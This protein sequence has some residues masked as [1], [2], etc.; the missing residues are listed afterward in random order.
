MATDPHKDRLR[1]EREEERKAL[2]RLKEMSE[3]EMSRMER[4]RGKNIFS[5]SKEGDSP[6]FGKAGTDEDSQRDQGASPFR[7]F[8]TSEQASASVPP[9]PPP[10]PPVDN[11]PQDDPRRFDVR[12]RDV[13][14]E[15][16][17]AMLT[18]IID[19]LENLPRD[20][21]DELTAG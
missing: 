14:Q 7:S 4:E 6:E 19:L 20:I 1:K 15:D 10:P 5:A 8:E 12:E 9:P 3:E 18:R 2:Q 21:A 11:P 16:I 17:P 13:Q